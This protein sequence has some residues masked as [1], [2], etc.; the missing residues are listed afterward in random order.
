ML[1]CGRGEPQDSVWKEVLWKSN[2]IRMRKLPIGM[3]LN[4]PMQKRCT[5]GTIM[6]IIPSW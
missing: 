5:F 4:E 2:Q 3:A 6:T 1:N